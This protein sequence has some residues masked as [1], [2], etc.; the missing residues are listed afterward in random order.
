MKKLVSIVVLAVMMP[1]LVFGGQLTSDI[2]QVSNQPDTVLSANTVDTNP[3]VQSA[4]ISDNNKENINVKDEAKTQKSHSWDTFWD[5]HF[6]G[7]RWVW[8]ALA[9]GALVAIHAA[10]AH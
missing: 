4:P 9:G 5:V 7:Y 2:T 1:S 3:N 8:W 6:G 10:A